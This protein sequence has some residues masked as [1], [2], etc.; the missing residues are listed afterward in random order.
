MESSLDVREMV[1][2]PPRVASGPCRVASLI[3]LGELARGLRQMSDFL[4]ETFTRVTDACL[5]GARPDGGR[6]QRPVPHAVQAIRTSSVERRIMAPPVL[7]MTPLVLPQNC[8]R[9]E[10]V[11]LPMRTTSSSPGLTTVPRGIS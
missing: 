8:M 5:F 6:Q 4:G 3:T 7:T 9:R 11:P 10:L 1:G 2:M